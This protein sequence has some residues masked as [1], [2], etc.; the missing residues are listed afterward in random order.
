[1]MPSLH[2]PRR[3]PPG[4]KVSVDEL[5]GLLMSLVKSHI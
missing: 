4:T 5:A 3:S 1:M 2:P